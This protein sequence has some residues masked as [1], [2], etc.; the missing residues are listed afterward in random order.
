LNINDQLLA[1]LGQ[2]G[3][4]VFFSVIFASSLGIPFPATFTLVVAGS[5]AA[6]G[7]MDIGWVLGLGILAAIAGDQAAYA[8]GHWGGD[9][10]VK[11][12]T[13]RF[14]GASQLEKA[15]K[16]V[17][18]WGWVG[19]FFTRWLVTSLGPWISYTSGISGYSY[20]RYLLWDISGEVV[21]VVLYVMAGELFSDRIQALMDTL[22]NLVWVEIGL[23]AAA[24]FGWLLFRSLRN[25]PKNLGSFPEKGVQN[26]R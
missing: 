17:N 26:D 20:Y 10:L 14:G 4:P 15:E 12:I 19:V 25:S 23:V 21:W 1:A 2:Y 11:R 5:F 18:R 16:A 7:N 22:G 13:G 6:L 24:V 3:L 9:R 8:I